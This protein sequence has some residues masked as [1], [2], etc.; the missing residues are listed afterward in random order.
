M[1]IH[2]W[3]DSGRIPDFLL[4][5]G[6][7]RR[8]NRMLNEYKG[9]DAQAEQKVKNDLIASL[10]TMP[11]AIATDEANEQHYE[12]PPRFFELVLGPHLKY[13]SCLYENPN[14]DLKEAEEAMLTLTCDRAELADGQEI[15]EIGCGWGS[16]TLFMAARYPGAK[17]TAIS[18]SRFQREFI[19]KRAEERGLTNV[20]VQTVDINNLDLGRQF[21]RVV[22]V[23]MFEHARN[24]RKLLGKVT[25]HLKPGGLLFVHIFA[26]RHMP[27]LFDHTDQ[28]NW[29]ARYFFAGGTMPSHDLLFY[30]TEGLTRVTHWVVD[31]RHYEK[32]LNA[33]LREMDKKQDQVR[34]VLQETY[35]EHWRAW[36]NRWRLFFI[37][38]AEFFGLN[39]GK[40]W[41]VV[42]YLFKKV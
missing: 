29:M 35:G 42:H 28:G 4:R 25:D 23:E 37:S 40:E 27:F 9:L 5:D 3:I 7:R 22:T 8:L 33:W 39:E 41:N 16:L 14:A 31:G 15:L 26:H 17:I 21:D 38:C 10:E 1:L 32:T 6:V 24:Y 30:F 11:I 2:Q 19:L 20:D 34:P 12:L 13:S 36:E 18:N